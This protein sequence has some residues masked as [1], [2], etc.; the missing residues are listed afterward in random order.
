MPHKT[1]K[2]AVLGHR[3]TQ[4]AA[5]NFARD[6]IHGKLREQELQTV[7]DTFSASAEQVI[8]SKSAPKEVS[9]KDIEQVF[10]SCISEKV[11]QLRR[12]KPKSIDEY[13][14]AAMFDCH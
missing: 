10:R 4:L 13:R 2:E 12:A 9:R 7:I 8:M 11:E 6:Q 1:I 3:L 5:L 14:L